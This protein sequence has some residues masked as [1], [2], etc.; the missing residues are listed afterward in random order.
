[1]TLKLGT[2]APILADGGL[3]SILSQGSYLTP[4]PSVM[5]VE[6]SVRKFAELMVLGQFLRSV[7]CDPHSEFKYV[8]FSCELIFLLSSL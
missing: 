7:V 2:M 6:D 1:M 4:N 8:K 5:K 3:A